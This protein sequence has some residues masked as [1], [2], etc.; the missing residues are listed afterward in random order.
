MRLLPDVPFPPYAFIP[1]RSPHPVSDPRGHSFG[2]T[3]PAPATLTPHQWQNSKTYLFGID[4]FNASFYWE[5]H[6]EF[7][8][9]WMACGRKGVV[10]D[11]LKG[12]IKMAAAGVKHLEGVPAG[13]LSHARRAADLWCEV[14]RSQGVNRDVFLGLRLATLID[15]A[16]AV[17]RSGWPAAAPVLISS[18]TGVENGPWFPP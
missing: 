18:V 17:V 10:A 3:T 14:S 15:L 5:S 12:L 9:L 16:E 13:T 2:I 7:E 1:G 4:L 8:A 6:V 11:F